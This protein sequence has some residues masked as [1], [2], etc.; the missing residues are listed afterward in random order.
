MSTWLLIIDTYT[1]LNRLHII[2]FVSAL[3]I[4]VCSTA[5]RSTIK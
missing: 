4:T 5:V 2:V 1:E 3:K